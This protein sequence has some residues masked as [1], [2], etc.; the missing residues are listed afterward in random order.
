MKKIKMKKK[1]LNFFIGQKFHEKIRLKKIK[2]IFHEIKFLGFFIE[3]IL[4]EKIIF[5]Q[6]F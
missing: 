5:N 3:Q 6:I 1:L 2:K 4:K